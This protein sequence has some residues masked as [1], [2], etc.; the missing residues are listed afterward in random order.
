MRQL[1]LLALL[2]LLA[3]AFLFG[4]VPVRA[5]GF[6]VDSTL[7]AVDATP[8]DGACRTLDGVCTLRAAVQEANALPGPD[9]ISLPSGVYTLALPGADEEAALS[10]D[11]DI[12]D[13]VTITGAGAAST[14]IDGAD[15]DRVLHVTANT[16]VTISGITVRNGSAAV[17]GGILNTGTVFLNDA[18]VSDNTAADDGGAVI[19]HGTFFVE[20][21]VFTGN[22]SGD[23]GGAFWGDGALELTDSTIAGNTAHDEGGAIVSFGGYVI[24]DK[25]TVSDNHALTI[26]GGGLVNFG[27]SSMELTNT[28]VS[29]NDAATLGGGIL[30]NG[31]LTL[32]LVTIAGNTAGSGGGLHNGGSVRIRFTIIASNTPDACA[33]GGTIVFS[34]AN[35]HD[36]GTCAFAGPGDTTDDPQLL[37]LADNGGLTMT[38]ALPQT[39]PAIDAAASC[40]GVSSDQ[41]GVRRPQGPACDIGAFELGQV[42]IAGDVSCD[43]SVNSIDALLVLQRSARLAGHLPCE[44]AADVNE[45]GSLSSLDAALILQFVAG[46]LH[47]LP[48]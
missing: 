13:D 43:G 41:R 17:A 10:G 9:T 25:S 40:G 18:V 48:P 33:G 6:S 28:T 15:L 35:M 27:K 47:Q 45:D 4:D 8:G 16:Q 34:S 46:L 23:N 14:I 19:N 12:T 1:A 29:G 3:S 36:D 22:T 37:P 31:V 5:A 26:R 21:S 44:S 11:L 32:E 20:R 39:S 30:N 7:D 2:A 24:L 38:H 42:P